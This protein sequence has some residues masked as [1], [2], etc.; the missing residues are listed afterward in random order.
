MLWLRDTIERMA[1][2]FLQAWLGAWLVLEDKAFDTL[3]TEDVLLV[4][5]VAAVGAFLFALGGA[6]VGSRDSASF[7][8]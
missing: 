5:F 1:R 2:T 8:G 7:Q 6:Q 3:F 4:G